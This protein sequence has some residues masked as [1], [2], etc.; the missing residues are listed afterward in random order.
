MSS[1]SLGD[2]SVDHTRNNV[3]INTFSAVEHNVLVSCYVGNVEPGSSILSY[4]TG[5]ITT[6]GTDTLDHNFPA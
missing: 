1:P 5:W 2:G 6:V 3:A 4:V